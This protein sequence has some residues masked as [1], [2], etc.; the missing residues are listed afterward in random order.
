MS[1]PILPGIPRLFPYEPHPY[2][3]VVPFTVRD[4]STML[5]ILNGLREWIRDKLI[6]HLDDNFTKMVEAWEQNVVQLT[7]S[8]NAALDA[9]SAEIA[10]LLADQLAEFEAIK[11]AVIEN[12]IELQ[13]EVLQAIFTDPDSEFRQLINT[14]YA[15]ADYE[16]VVDALDLANPES[17]AREGLDP[18]YLPADFD[19]TAALQ[20]EDPD[21]PAREALDLLYAARRVFDVKS[22]GALGDGVTDDSAAILAAI[23]AARP[24]RGEVYFPTGLYISSQTL[25]L[26]SNVS[27]KGDGPGSS[28]VKLA[29]GANKDLLRSL[30][31][32][33]LDGGTSQSGPDRFVLSG[34]RFDGN[35]GEQSAESW[36][37]R[38][39][40]RA[41]IVSN[42]EFINGRNGNVQSQW[43][44]GGLD[45]E[46]HWTDFRI[47]G[48]VAGHGMD[49]R[50]PH[51]SVFVNGHVYKNGEDLNLY[52]GIVIQGNAAGEKFAN[53]HV[54]GHHR[55][56][57]NIRKMISAHGCVSEGASNANLLIAATRTFWGGHVYGRADGSSTTEV[58]IQIGDGTSGPITAYAVNV[59]AFGFN[60]ASSK[61]VSFEQDSGGHLSG[62]INKG[63]PTQAIHGSYIH[64]KTVML[65][66]VPD[67][68]IDSFLRT[69]F[70]RLDGVSP[71]QVLVSGSDRMRVTGG[72]VQFAN[73]VDLRGYTDAYETETWRIHSNWG[74]FRPRAYTSAGLPNAATAGAGAMVYNT[75][76]GMP[77][78][79]NG[80]AWRRPDGSAI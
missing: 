66:T 24:V 8:V 63:V 53:V 57:W 75:T 59:V 30:D 50:G 4:N 18:L 40:A 33:T 6:P 64:P 39:Y 43:G 26:Y 29:P 11:Q 28:R 55:H 3:N 42:C 58:G 38:V 51:D 56:G 80:T 72:V 34:L 45:M 67:G 77:V 78:F 71:L 60:H 68:S 15:P 2:T 37:M 12:S 1:S 35:G 79:S 73:Q 69:A 46:A 27:Y 23:E 65:L 21:S 41:Y 49:W 22:Y 14:L 44:T 74:Y 48:A 25:T 62:V 5:M 52:D 31:F 47:W 13:D 16:G 70:A 54:W 36:T 76:L 32:A 9:Q 10:S 7:A 20:L 17:P 61:P 19:A